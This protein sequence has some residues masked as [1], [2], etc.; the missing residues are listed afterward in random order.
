[1]AGRIVLCFS[2][3]SYVCGVVQTAIAT[4]AAQEAEGARRA[5]ADVL[6]G[7]RAIA[8]E[9]IALEEQL[10]E[11]RNAA[12][13]AQQERSELESRLAAGAGEL[14]A[15]EGRAAAAAERAEREKDRLREEIATLQEGRAG[16]MSRLKEMAARKGPARGDTGAVDASSQTEGA[17]EPREGQQE[18]ACQASVVQD[19]LDMARRALGEVS[20]GEGVTDEEER[21]LRGD[22]VSARIAEQALADVAGL[23]EV[24]GADGRDVLLSWRALMPPAGWGSGVAAT[25]ADTQHSVLE[26][27]HGLLDG[28]AEERAQR[29]ADL[30]E[31]DRQIEALKAALVV[32]GATV[33]PQDG[34]KLQGVRGSPEKVYAEFGADPGPHVN[35]NDA[36]PLSNGGAS[37]SEVVRAGHSYE[38]RSNGDVGMHG[39]GGGVPQT[40]V[41]AP[42][43]VPEIQSL[44]FAQVPSDGDVGSWRGD[45]GIFHGDRDEAVLGA[46]A[47]ANVFGGGSSVAGW[48]HVGPVGAEGVPV[49]AMEASPGD[50]ATSFQ[51]GSASVEAAAA[52][53][54]TPPPKRGWFGGIFG[55]RTP[56]PAQARRN[57]LTAD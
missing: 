42:S 47:E 18:A 33:P 36:V 56:S 57:I 27:V 11:L 5:V 10:L 39:A 14:R 55:R 6:E 28:L 13:A 1:M 24:M 21:L 35:G 34:G 44:G 49:G 31:K 50:T 52:V 53:V 46:A 43:A 20:E 54:H 45:D 29:R 30:E 25:V 32:A 15:A 51:A 7:R 16:L 19:A 8:E 26:S 2:S 22:A 41:G 23:P 4:E 3:F 37:P 17:A 9:N 12:A 48:E 40:G 38:N